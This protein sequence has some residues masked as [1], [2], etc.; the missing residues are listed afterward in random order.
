MPVR[1]M[2]VWLTHQTLL[3]V[4]AVGHARWMTDD[5]SLVFQGNSVWRRSV[6]TRAYRLHFSLQLLLCCPETEREQ[7]L[8]DTAVE[9][10]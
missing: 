1:N 6:A 9:C 10:W 5:L 2:V 7:C 3:F 4:Q 8:T